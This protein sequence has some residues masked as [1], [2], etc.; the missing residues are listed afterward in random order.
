MKSD[1]H[2][3]SVIIPT[4]GRETLALSKAALK[5]QTRPPDELII[6]VD[7]DR[8]GQCWA[9]NKGFS[10]AKG[11]LIVFTDD[12]CVH[13]KDWLERMI[14]AID[15]Y[16]AAMV[17]SHYNET[18]PLLNEIRLRRKFPTTAQINPVGFVGTG[19][20]VI[21][22]RESLEECI[23]ID[24]FIFN[25][26]FAH[27]GCEDIELSI[28]LRKRGHDLVFIDNRIKHLKKVTPLKFMQFQ[29]DRGIGIGIL[30]RIQK[31]SDFGQIPDKSLLWQ[32]N[33]RSSHVI[34][35]FRMLYK[36][37]LGPFD[38]TSFSSTKHF[39]VFWFGEKAQAI[40]FLYAMLL[41]K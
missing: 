20:N 15:K 1:S 23:S 8:L 11:N 34:K 3:V 4:I 12:D 24:G 26:S 18:D 30:Y 17:S 13:D 29:F 36:K 6:V 32:N 41:K 19:G 2:I 14:S 7:K 40:G 21:Y 27:Y 39:I 38:V 9:K 33:K 5:S 22:K 10:K 28:R 35:W 31:K 16:D 25:L 37:V